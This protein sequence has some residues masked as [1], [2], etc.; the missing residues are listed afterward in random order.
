M[1]KMPRFWINISA[2]KMMQIV[3]RLMPTVIALPL[4]IKLSRVQELP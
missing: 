2:S 4:L 3:M 1:K